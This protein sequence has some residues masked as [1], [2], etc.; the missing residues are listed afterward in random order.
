M[1]GC[2]ARGSLDIKGFAAGQMAPHSSE[3]ARFLIVSSEKRRCVEWEIAN[4]RQAK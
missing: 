3:H 4:T 2:A 1:K